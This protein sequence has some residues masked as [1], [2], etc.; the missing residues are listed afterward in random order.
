M[1]GCV[2]TVTAAL[3][4]ISNKWK[5]RPLRYTEEQRTHLECWLR[6]HLSRFCTL[7]PFKELVHFRD[8]GIDESMR[9]T[10]NP[11]AVDRYTIFKLRDLLLW[12]P[13]DKIWPRILCHDVSVYLGSADCGLSLP[14]VNHLGSPCIHSCH[15]YLTIAFLQHW[16]KSNVKG[17]KFLYNFYLS[18]V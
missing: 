5:W 10:D 17:W 12:R 4:C 18:L 2:Q 6:E 8:L 11:T 3:I 15:P 1:R 16:C 14:A 13:R 7:R 9:R